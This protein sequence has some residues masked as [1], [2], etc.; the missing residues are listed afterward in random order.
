MSNSKE[1][2]SPSLRR[3][4]S[5]VS[6]RPDIMTQYTL[7]EFIEEI[8][9]TLGITDHYLGMCRDCRNSDTHLVKHIWES[10]STLNPDTIR[11]GRQI[12]QNVRHR[13][14]PDPE[15]LLARQ[16]KERIVTQNISSM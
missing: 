1:T 6:R 5:A 12:I 10:H 15:V 9:T 8:N 3:L 16:S 13:H 14:L 11:R 7:K 2:V 4:K